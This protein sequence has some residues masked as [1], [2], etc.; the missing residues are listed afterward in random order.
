[1]KEGGLSRK[2]YWGA[3]SW[4]L[5]FSV[6]VVFPLTLY[7]EKGFLFLIFMYFFSLFVGAGV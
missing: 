6:L 3:G 5:V 1:V 2:V 7:P 4:H